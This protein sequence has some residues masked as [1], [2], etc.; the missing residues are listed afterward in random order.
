MTKTDDFIANRLVWKASSHSLPTK[1]SFYY[2]DIS[3]NTQLYVN[4]LIDIENSGQPVLFFT[5][6]TGEWTLICTREVICN[7]NE[8]LVRINISDIESFK[9]PFFDKLKEGKHINPEEIKKSELDELKVITRSGNSFVLHAN[10]GSD[11]FALWNI[12]L[13]AARLT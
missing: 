4:S 5:K 13:M 3:L 8:T 1:F 10:K 2:K 9:P 11:L 12:L 6:P 7:N